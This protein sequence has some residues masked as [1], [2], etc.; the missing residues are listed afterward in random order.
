MPDTPADPSAIIARLERQLARERRAREEAEAIAERSTRDLYLQVQTLEQTRRDLLAA[1]ESAERASRASSAFLANMSHEIRTPLNA[2]LGLAYI[3]LRSP[4]DDRVRKHVTDLYDAGQ[5][6]LALLSDVLDVSKFEAGKLE[7]ERVDFSLDDV[8]ERV[9]R[10][11][12]ERAQ[13]KGL[14]LVFGRAHDAPRELQGDPLRLA[15]ILLN[16]LSNAVKFTER[17]T[18]SVRVSV[19]DETDEGVLL[20]FA[21]S[22]TGPGLDAELC[23]RLFREFEQGDASTTRRHGGTG[24]GLAITRRLAQAMG[25]AVG[26]ESV[27]GEGSTFWFTARLRRGNALPA[28]PVAVRG[29]RALVVDDHDVARASL[30]EMLEAHGLRAEVAA[31]G[32]AALEAVR[33]A[34][35]REQPFDVVLL[36]WR[37]PGMDGVAIAQALHHAH[38]DQLAPQVLMVTA[39]AREDALAATE[40]VGIE[41]ILS[42]PVTESSL[43]DALT[44]A[45]T[46]AKGQSRALASTPPPAPPGDVEAQLRGARVL[47]VDDAPLNLEIAET[48]LATAGAVVSTAENGLVA[49]ERVRRER[50]DVVLMDMQMPVMDG[51]AAATLIR[52]MPGDAGQVPIAA[53]TANVLERDRDRCLAAGMQAV[54]TKPIDP[55]KL[56]ALVAQ[57]RRPAP[58]TTAPPQERA[59]PV[60][61][62]ETD[63]RAIDL[64]RALR[65]TGDNRALLQRV[66]KRFVETHA[67]EAL[68]IE[69]DLARDARADA[70]RRAHTLKGLAGTL[71]MLPL[72]RRARALEA[73]LAAGEGSTTFAPLLAATSASLGVAVEAARSA[74]NPAH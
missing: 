27:P 42:K 22:D 57:L 40:G 65:N 17:G 56:Y 2:I 32:L 15:Q 8:L 38:R 35:A 23:G 63:E 21:V 39:H 73:A 47:V 31:S 71:G 54:L 45:L 72:E 67:D 68:A 49:V 59:A 66:L 14:E 51:I 5:H 46:R 19:E 44:T 3:V 62:S 13:A 20:R 52:A 74:L 58:A 12:A 55:P 34:L 6:L 33:S 64:E 16:Y 36:D 37:M 1:K 10:M 9:S 18:V 4:I 53:V 70:T 43:L 28:I 61:P 11:V 60:D 25:G 48:L 69:R 29:K 30:R 7:L 26:V 41:A 50:F 24:L